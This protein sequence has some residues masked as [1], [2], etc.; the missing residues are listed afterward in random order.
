MKGKLHILIVV[1]LFAVSNL[2]VVHAQYFGRNKPSYKVFDYK[3]FQ[4]PHFEIYH[5]WN[6]DTLLLKL[7]RASETWYNRHQY[8]LHDTLK[9]KNPLIVYENHADFQQTDAIMGEISVGTGGV[10]EAMKNRVVIPIQ[11]SWAQTNH[12]LGHE[13]VHAFQYNIVINGDSSSIGNLRNLPLWMVEGMAEYMSIGS[14]DSHT[15]M[16]MRDAVINKDFP[17]L[18]MLSVDYRYFPYRYGQA[19]WAFTTRLYGDSIV[20]PLF[21][22]TSLYGYEEAFEKLLGYDVKTYSN[23]WKTANIDYYRKWIK[24]TD[25]VDRVVGRKILSTENAGRMNLAPTISPNGKYVAFLSEKDIFS[26]DLFLADAYSGNVL[27]NLANTE[28]NPQ[29]DDFSFVESA[30]TWS[31]DNRFLAFVIVSKGK[32]KLLV[33][34]VEKPKKQKEYEIPGVPALSNPAWS[35]NGDKV[36][37][38]GQVGGVTSLYLFE[39]STGKFEKLTT[40]PYAHL[41]PSW[42]TDGTQIVFTTDKPLNTSDS[43][44]REGYRLGVFSLIN[45]T[46]KYYDIFGGAENL[47]PVFSSDNKSIFFLSNSDGFRNIYQFKIDSNKV[48]RLTNLITGVS[49]ITP[50]SPAMSV[51]RDSNLLVYS[52]YFKGNY[53][54]YRAGIE[55]FKQVEVNPNVIDMRAAMLP[56]GTVVGD[57]VIDKSLQ[58]NIITEVPADSMKQIPYKAKFKLDYIGNTGVGVATS[59]YGTGIAGSVDFLFS[60]IVGNNTLYSSLSL[61]GEIYDFG[62]MLAYIN[63][64]NRIDWGVSV[65]HVPYRFGRMSQGYDTVEFKRNVSTVVVDYYRLFQEQVS[66]FASY[67]FSSTQRFEISTSL[68]QY[69]YRLDRYTYFYDLGTYNSLGMKRDKDLPTPS[70]FTI[71]QLEAAYVIDNSYFGIASPLRGYRSRFSVERYFGGVDM[72]TLQLDYRKYFYMRPFCLAFRGMHYGRYGKGSENTVMSPLFLGYPWYVRGYDNSYFYSNSSGVSIDQLQG[73]R[74]IVS[75]IELRVPFTGPDKVSLIGSKMFYT[76]LAIFLDGGLAWTASNNP[77]WSVNY[78]AAKEDLTKRLPVF[79]AGLS[80]RVNLFG[81]MILEPFYAFPLGQG[82]NARAFGLNFFPGW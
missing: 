19:F 37:I 57:N 8:M 12:V 27:K 43:I 7:A 25:T 74:M 35:P 41:Q 36:V 62:G 58:N 30:G 48:V 70:G 5:Y 81:A 54:I 49:G 18:E 63:S 66:L 51:A 42:S 79:S 69:S 67:P 24:E 47:N 3:V 59:R 28:R 4:T 23:L 10:T 6:H 75:N 46:S 44:N 14:I 16:W 65:S 17:T 55:E 32:N 34:D 60:D 11:D 53:T 77:T 2:Y 21:K 50:F 73:S 52:H 71:E 45:R 33:I 72:F 31:P 26:I 20:R 1:V 40:D 38:S 22:L 78:N 80:F 15:A 56:P 82:K 68:S 39:I 13:L 64:K 9:F 76:E 61:N 29:I